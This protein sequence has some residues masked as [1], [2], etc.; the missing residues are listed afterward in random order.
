MT[1][2][3]GSGFE[4]E[5]WL[6]EKK[7]KILLLL[8]SFPLLLKISKIALLINKMKIRY[9]ISSA[10]LFHNLFDTVF[11]FKGVGKDFLLFHGVEEGNPLLN[12]FDSRTMWCSLLLVLRTL[13]QTEVYFVLAPEASWYFQPISWFVS[14][15]VFE[16]GD[17]RTYWPSHLGC[18]AQPSVSAAYFNNIIKL[19][20]KGLN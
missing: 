12:S 19:S 17:K 14:I 6:T 20:P 15:S 16:N 11:L 8:S 3:G 10:A 9:C 2:L 4:W 1:W 5:Q 13:L 18:S 7:K